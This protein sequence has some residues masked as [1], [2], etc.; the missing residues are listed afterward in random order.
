LQ[1]FVCFGIVIFTNK[2]FGDFFFYLLF[3]FSL[4]LLSNLLH[5]LWFKR[6]QNCLILLIVDFNT[7]LVNNFLSWI[8]L[9]RTDDLLQLRLIYW[10]QFRRTWCVWAILLIFRG[11]NGIYWMYDVTV[12][13]VL[14][15]DNLSLQFITTI[16][17]IHQQ[18]SLLLK[19]LRFIQLSK[20]LIFEWIDFGSSFRIELI[21]E[22]NVTFIKLL[23][24]ILIGKWI[25]LS[26]N[27]IKIIWQRLLYRFWNIK[28]V[29][30][31]HLD[32]SII[33]I[34]VYY[35]FFLIKFLVLYDISIM[36][37]EEI[38]LFLLF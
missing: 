13:R 14:H 2:F 36:L 10:I 6:A 8:K 34:F 27:A 32:V 17:F 18:R 16:W 26:L 7:L 31:F 15:I 19:R 37:I 38:S 1:V 21:N 30:I 28:V 20:H 33:I 4:Y 11:Y 22:M 3:K 29:F 5:Y 12:F 24:I 35:F 9:L 25:K 23:V